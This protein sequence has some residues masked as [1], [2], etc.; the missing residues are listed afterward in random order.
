MGESLP[1][2]TEAQWTRK[3]ACLTK[4]VV[5]QVNVAVVKTLAKNGDLEGVGVVYNLIPTKGCEMTKDANEAVIKLMKK[6]SNKHVIPSVLNS[7]VPD[8]EA[9][10]GS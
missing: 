8:N 6:E 10:R 3:V 2:S 1:K 7:S 9:K 4:E 5:T